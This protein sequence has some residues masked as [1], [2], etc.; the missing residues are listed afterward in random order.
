MHNNYIDTNEMENSLHSIYI[1]AQE[2]NLNLTIYKC[3]Q[4]LCIAIYFV[5]KWKTHIFIFQGLIF[6]W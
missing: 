6:P 5:R 1:Y 4:Y 3:T 2:K